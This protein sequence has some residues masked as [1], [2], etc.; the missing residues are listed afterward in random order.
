MATGG[1][2]ASL[3]ASGL[4]LICYNHAAALLPFAPDAAGVA[5]LV[6]GGAVLS[7]LDKTPPAEPAGKQE[8]E[9]E[10][11]PLRDEARFAA[12]CASIERGTSELPT[13]GG[14]TAATP[15][16]LDGEVEALLVPAEEQAAAAEA[17][18]REERAKQQLAEVR[19]SLAEGSL[20]AR[21]IR[22]KLAPRVFVVDFDVYAKSGTGP[23][24]RPPTTREL[25]EVLREQ[26]N[27]LLHICSPYDEVCLRVT[28][29]GGAVM[30]YGLAAAQLGR[31]RAAG[32]RTSAC[33]D[34]VAA[35]GGYM[36]ASVADKL[37]AAPFS[38][39]GS[40]GVVAGVPNLHRLLERGGVEYIQRTGGEHKRTV[41]MLTPNTEEGLKKFEEDIGLV[42]EAFKAHVVQHRPEVEASRVCTGESW[43]ALQAPAGLLDEIITSDAYLR[44][45]QADADVILL[46]AA[47][48]KR[49]PGL[50]GL[51]QRGAAQ[52]IEAVRGAIAAALGG[53]LG[54]GG[55]AVGTLSA[56]ALTGA[57]LLRAGSAG[58]LGAE[59]GR[60]ADGGRA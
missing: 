16:S 8:V 35:S 48:K 15:T 28:S 51:V 50:L 27:L 6:G 26:V 25:L 47:P 4:G 60:G 49:P 54:G 19:T 46:R 11:L 7:Q 21:R 57:P 42:H 2:A 24:A 3:A 59:A 58:L 52:G 30:D 38:I 9:F 22:Q 18:A 44:S 5:L 40:I 31:L 43:L 12:A 1:V 17:A 20:S 53:A 56:G 36:L 41:N 34:T 10:L 14:I 37:M 33:V 55:D 13:R 32:V 23:T 39:V 45:R 29:P